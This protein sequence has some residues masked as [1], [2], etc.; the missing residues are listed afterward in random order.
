MKTNVFFLLNHNLFLK[1]QVWPNL[2][3]QTYF[4]SWN[5]KTQI[6]PNLM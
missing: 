5:L 6:W 2:M 3:L 1:T 4:F